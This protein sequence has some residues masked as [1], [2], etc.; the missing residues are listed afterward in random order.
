MEQ[1]VDERPFFHELTADEQRAAFASAVESK[2]TWGEFGALYRQPTWCRY[3]DALY[4]VMGCWS[5]TS[6]G[7]VTGRDYCR[8]CELS[9][10]YAEPTQ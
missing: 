3:P 10:D 5:L 9:A 8:N 7:M 1:A 6:P 2:L 4:G